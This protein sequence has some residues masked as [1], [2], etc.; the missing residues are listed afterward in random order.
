VLYLA[1]PGL[2]IR[3]NIEIQRVAIPVTIW[4][5]CRSCRYYYNEIIIAVADI[6]ANLNM[7]QFSF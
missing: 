6:V 4:N 7:Y 3:I 5:C 1:T 2:V